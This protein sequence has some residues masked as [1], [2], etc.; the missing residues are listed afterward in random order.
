M[1]GPRGSS[2]IGLMNSWIMLQSGV[3]ASLP[4]VARPGRLDVGGNVKLVRVALLQPPSTS[5]IEKVDD[6]TLS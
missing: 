5:R 1:I 2:P 4:A 3:I 6:A